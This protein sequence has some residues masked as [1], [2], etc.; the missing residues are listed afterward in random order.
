M[1]WP[2]GG[3]GGFILNRVKFLNRT[4]KI[5]IHHKLNPIQNIIFQYQNDF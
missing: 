2:P 5:K 1:Y 4:K 3:G